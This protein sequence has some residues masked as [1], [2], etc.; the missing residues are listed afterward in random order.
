MIFNRIP[1]VRI[2]LPLIIGIIAQLLFSFSHILIT[3]LLLLSFLST[4]FFYYYLSKKKNR[5]SYMFIY[6]LSVFFFFSGIYISQ[7]RKIP[8]PSIDENAQIQYIAS[9]EEDL[10]ESK[11][12]YKTFIRIEKNITNNSK[13]DVLIQAYFRKDTKVKTLKYGDRL[14]INTSLKSIKA[15][16][17]PYEFNYADYLAK[18]GIYYQA[19]LEPENF[20]FL[21]HYSGFSL[22]YYANEVRNKLLSIFKAHNFT[23]N[24][25]AVVSALTLGYKNYLDPE[26]K[27]AFSDTGAMHVLAVSGLHVGAI[28]GV[29][30]FIFRPFERNKKIQLI[31]VFVIIFSLWAFAFV[32]GLS[33]SVRRAALMFTFVAIGNYYKRSGS[34]YNSLW[35]SASLL[36]LY[37]PSIFFDVGFQLSYLAVFSIVALQ[38]VIYKSLYVK[39]KILNYFWELTSVSIAAQIGTMPLGILYFNQFPTYFIFTNLVIIPVAF[40]IIY[41]TIIL[42]SIN[43]IPILA[44]SIAW[45]L[46]KNVFLLNYWVYLIQS[47]PQSTL[48]GLEMNLFEII[49]FYFFI[50]FLFSYFY[51]KKKYY[52]NVSFAF[53]L[54]LTLSN[55]IGNYLKSKESHFVVLNVNKSSALNFANSH[56]NIVFCDSVLWAKKNSLAFTAKNF[57]TK[58]NLPSPQVIN[59]QDSTLTE[60]KYKT[61]YYKDFF[62]YYKKMK[63]AVLGYQEIK[64]YQIYEKIKVDFVILANNC[65]LKLSEIQNYFDPQIVIISSSNNYKQIEKWKKEAQ[66][67]KVDLHIVSEDGAFVKVIK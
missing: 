16:G 54:A 31:K 55:G 29:L 11:T 49:L 30:I 58:K 22:Y 63:I 26:I 33:P 21:E 62:I 18:K 41:L 37:A 3:V 43:Y 51:I 34:I 36:L 66:L 25:L 61:L 1:F 35:A 64:N 67:Q 39:N 47:L 48:Q 6:N 23:G 46:N 9:I 14:L 4:L 28:L 10:S 15:K 65:K 40:I 5:F 2:A 50:T 52:L 45:L 38:P 20:Q 42:F 17:N 44:S 59:I 27:Q 19:Y 24:E 53:L 32:S 13:S 12:F 56:E 7:I 57:W 60:K 8:K